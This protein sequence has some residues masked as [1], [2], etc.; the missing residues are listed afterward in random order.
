MDS[1][2]K[3]KTRIIKNQTQRGKYNIYSQLLKGIQ[4]TSKNRGRTKDNNRFR[5]RSASKN[6]DIE[7]EKVK[8]K[9]EV[10]DSY[11]GSTIYPLYSITVVI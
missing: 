10:K 5:Y 4:P 9:R 8:N 7:I 1:Y 11:Q 3:L 6:I 2:S